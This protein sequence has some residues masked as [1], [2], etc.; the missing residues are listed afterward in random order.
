MTKR[1]VYANNVFDWATCALVSAVAVAYDGPVMQMA[2]PA[3]YLDAKDLKDVAA[4]GIVREDVLDEIY[5]ISDIP[6]P[7]Q[8]MISSEG[9]DNSYT[10]WDEDKLAAPDLT[11][12][13]VSGSDANSTNNKATVANVK[14]V[15]NHGQ[16]SDKL[17]IVTERSEAVN[18]IGLAGAMGYQT[19]RR[20]QELRRDQEAIMLSGQASVADDNNTTAGQSAGAAAW[21]TTNTS[22]GTSGASAGFQTGTKLVTAMVAGQKRKLTWALLATQIQNVYKLGGNPSV[23]MSIPDITKLVGQYLFTTPYAAQPTANVNGTGGGVNQTSQGYIDT[24][25]TDFG[26]LMNIVPNRLQQPYSSADDPVADVGVVYGLDPRFWKK[27][28][29][30]GTKVEPLA[31]VG[32][33]HRKYIHEDW[34]LACLLERANF[35]IYDIDPTQAMTAS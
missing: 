1:I 33:S 14:R 10:E 15:G 16:I 17:V 29:L 22:H 13:R 2:A 23:L 19:T 21:I 3:D 8:D 7:F 27:K 9:M 32:L 12:K 24:F 26:T 4:G 5:D 25:K 28:S 35:A 30:Y 18:S 20:L 31:K 34:T 6:T 11:N